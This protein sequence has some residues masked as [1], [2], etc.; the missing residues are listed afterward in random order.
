[1]ISCTF[2]LAFIFLNK[3]FQFYVQDID[4]IG[5]TSRKL[6]ASDISQKT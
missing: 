2:F 3:S 4:F 5:T 1:M 6:V